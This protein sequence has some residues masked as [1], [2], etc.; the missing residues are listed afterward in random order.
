M[1]DERLVLETRKRIDNRD[2]EAVFAGGGCFH[3][4]L[5]L[6]ERFGYKIRGIRDGHDPKRWSHV[7]CQKGADSKGVDIRGVYYENL[8]VMLA[9]GGSTAAVCDVLVDEIRNTIRARKYPSEL[10]SEIFKLADWIVDTH[11]RFVT[12]KPSN[13]KLY[14]QFLKNIENGHNGEPAA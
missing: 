8:L 10:E 12:A 4:A 2:Y 6:H 13:E 9:N 1:C 3:F 7:W 11:E 14:A 5:R